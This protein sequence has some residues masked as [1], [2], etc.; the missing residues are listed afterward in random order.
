MF[1]QPLLLPDLLFTW[2]LTLNLLP[3]SHPRLLSSLVYIIPA[4]PPCFLSFVLSVFSLLFVPPCPTAL[5]PLVST[6]AVASFQ[7]PFPPSSASVSACDWGHAASESVLLQ[8][9]FQSKLTQTG[10]LVPAAH[11]RV[12]LRGPKAAQ[13]LHRGPPASLV[14]A[15]FVPQQSQRCYDYTKVQ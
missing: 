4:V 11:G 5:H 1:V 12:G 9:L 10:S 14:T 6:N 7:S 15:N 2:C 8:Q 3:T 13:L